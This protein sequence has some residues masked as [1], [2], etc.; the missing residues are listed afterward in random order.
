MV[1]NALKSY[2]PRRQNNGIGKL[3][4]MNKE[5]GLINIWKTFHLP[6]R[7]FSHVHI[8]RSVSVITKKRLTS[9]VKVDVIGGI[10]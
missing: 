8:H 6:N 4:N 1:K 3:N 7:I 9:F 10:I 5:L 2:I